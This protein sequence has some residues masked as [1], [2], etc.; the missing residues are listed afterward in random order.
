MDILLWL[1]LA[2]LPLGVAVAIAAVVTAAIAGLRL[3]G[4]VLAALVPVLLGIWVVTTY[5]SGL[6]ADETGTGG[7]IFATAGWLGGAVMAALAAAGLSIR[8]RPTP[9]PLRTASRAQ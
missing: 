9:I 5:Q 2:A 3:P 1:A 4:A 7:N 8:R 6:R